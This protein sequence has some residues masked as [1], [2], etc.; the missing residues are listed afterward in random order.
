MKGLKW[1]LKLFDKEFHYFKRKQYKKLV[2]WDLLF[3]RRYIFAYLVDMGLC[4]VVK[5]KHLYEINTFFFFLVKYKYVK[6][7]F[8]ILYF[9]TGMDFKI[10]G[11]SISYKYIRCARLSIK[12][13]IKK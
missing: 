7:Y 11:Y 9:F 6:V 1:S 8:G 10:E 12:R 4:L 5:R 13:L 3:H 2:A